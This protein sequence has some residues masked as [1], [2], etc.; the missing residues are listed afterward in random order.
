M[1][2]KQGLTILFL[3]TEEFSEKAG[4]LKDMGK[5]QKI[6]YVCLND[7]ATNVSERLQKKGIDTRKLFFIDTLS[8]HYINQE[9]TERCV[10]VSS[11]YGMDEIFDVI[12]RMKRKC[13]LFVFD[14]ISDL[15]KYH[16]SSSILGFTNKMKK[17]NLGKILYMLSKHNQAYEDDI[18]CFINDLMMFA[19]SKR[20]LS[21]KFNEKEEIFSDKDSVSGWPYE[22]IGLDTIS[23]Q[24]TSL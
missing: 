24:E 4:I 18:D 7:K 22:A 13:N 15:L 2:F 16:E 19:D 23:Y 21:A 5:N 1:I 14:D 20:E 9:S 10:Y 17:N 6:C 11:P 3:N 8:S 12:L